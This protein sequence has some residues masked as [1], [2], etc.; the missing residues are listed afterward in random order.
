M[1]AN[2]T[3][4]RHLPTPPPNATSPSPPPPNPQPPGR[5]L[6]FLLPFTLLL[7][8]PAAAFFSFPHGHPEVTAALTPYTAVTTLCSARPRFYPT[9]EE[10]CCN[11]CGFTPR[12]CSSSDLWVT[13]AHWTCITNAHALEGPTARKGGEIKITV[14]RPEAFLDLQVAWAKPGI[15]SVHK[16]GC[17]IAFNAKMVRR[18]RRCRI[19]RLRLNVIRIRIRHSRR[20]I[21]HSASQPRP[22]V[23]RVGDGACVLTPTCDTAVLNDD[24]VDNDDDTDDNQRQTTTM[25]TT[26]TG[27][28]PEYDLLRCERTTVG[29]PV[30][31]VVPVGGGEVVVVVVPVVVVLVVLSFLSLLCLSSLL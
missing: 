31:V 16:E 29:E 2:A 24:A 4:Q 12:G 26:T 3:S 15:P 30:V 28:E 19:C 7:P 21:H 6:L 20:H 1:V 14:S 22:P 11:Q 10:S 9:C 25:T 23:A 27:R 13:M 17:V 18:R 5:C 8:P